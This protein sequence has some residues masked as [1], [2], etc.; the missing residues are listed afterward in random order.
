MTAVRKIL[1]TGANGQLGRSF[2]DIEGEYP[3]FQFI[4]LSKEDVS[5]CDTEKMRKYFSTHQPQF[6]VNCA[7]Y[8][9]VDKAESEP[10][11]AMQVN[12]DAV[13]SLASLCNQFNCQFVHI[14]TDYVFNGRA[15]RPYREEDEPDP[16]NVYGQSKFEGEIL[17]IQNNPTSIIIRTS[18]V[19][20]AYGRNFVTTMLR[21]MKERPEIAVVDDQ[22]GSPTYA[23]DLAKA[24]M[25]I[26]LHP[27]LTVNTPGFPS[28][29]YH[30]CNAG[31]ASW[32]DF[33]SAIKDFTGSTC[34][35]KRI[36]TA[37]YATPASRP[38][39]S[40]LDSSR[41]QKEFGIEL[42]EWRSSLLDCLK[43]LHSV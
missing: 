23:T 21:L 27:S 34:L 28:R 42:K 40:V 17:A 35:I 12:R 18:W 6:L 8:T 7:A 2:Q 39:W 25:C 3:D 41:I 26:L 11:L 13:G 29:L 10:Y 1:V 14:S 33:A 30:F 31:I 20:A 19:Y 36:K 9:A 38:A 37:D 4:F 15:S 22:L 32:F 5:I 24:V 43:K 16:Q